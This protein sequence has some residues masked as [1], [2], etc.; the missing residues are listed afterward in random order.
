MVVGGFEVQNP[1]DLLSIELLDV[2]YV[3]GRY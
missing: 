3:V 2:M 1:R